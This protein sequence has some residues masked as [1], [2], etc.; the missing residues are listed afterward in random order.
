MIHA[1][2]YPSLGSA[3]EL[4]SSSAIVYSD[5][6]LTAWDCSPIM[7]LSNYSLELW[8]E[9][10]IAIAYML[11]RFALRFYRPGFRLFDRTDFFFALSTVC[12]LSLQCLSN[13]DASTPGLVYHIDYL[14]LSSTNAYVL[15]LVNSTTT[16]NLGSCFFQQYQLDFRDSDG[17][18][19]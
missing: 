18:S 7:A 13:S 15:T 1:L 19:R 9:S 16:L 11:F 2:I 8:I 5:K 17:D 12:Q 14:R 6:S 3:R 10:S 4:P